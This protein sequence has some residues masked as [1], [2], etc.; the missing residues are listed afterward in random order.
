MPETC[1]KILG[2][3]P[4]DG[5]KT[6]YYDD[7]AVDL[8]RLATGGEL[9]GPNGEI[10]IDNPPTYRRVDATVFAG[11][12]V[13]LIIVLAIW[14]HAAYRQLPLLVDRLRR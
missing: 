8:P 6:G 9:R 10:Y 11:E 3:F 7:P 5:C 12:V 1:T 4:S 2:L 14:L 13:F